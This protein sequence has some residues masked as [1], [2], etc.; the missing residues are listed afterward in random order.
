MGRGEGQ[1]NTPTKHILFSL[2]RFRRHFK[3]GVCLD[4]LRCNRIDQK[5]I[6]FKN[7]RF[8]HGLDIKTSYTI[9]GILILSISP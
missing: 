5:S 6:K 1:Y 9:L 8:I 2:S 3:Y 4:F 7:G